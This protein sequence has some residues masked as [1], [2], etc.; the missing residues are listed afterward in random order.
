M[1][2]LTG[3]LLAREFAVFRYQF[4]YMEAGRK[5]PDPP[6]LL[7][8]T[9]RA[10]CAEAASAGKGLPLFAGGKSL[11]GRMTSQA[12]A[13]AP[14]DGVRGI[15]FVGF[16]LHPQNRPDDRRAEHLR[17]I[18]KPLLFLQGERDALAEIGRMRTL[19][20]TLPNAT[21]REFPG[22]D[23]GFHVLKRSGQTDEG[24]LDALADATRA[25]VSALL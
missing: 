25:W 24:V 14:L 21:L 23:H 4:P 9:V 10:A 6:K 18:R 17:S 8:Q 5:L 13:D 11:G 2:A 15:V 3:R 12:E 19:C 16:P 1:N 22:A 20:R 7:T